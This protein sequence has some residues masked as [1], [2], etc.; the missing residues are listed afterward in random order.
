MLSDHLQSLQGRQVEKGTWFDVVNNLRE[1]SCKS[2]NH[3][4][5]YLNTDINDLALPFNIILLNLIFNPFIYKLWI[6]HKCA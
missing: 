6:Y 1:A 5:S 2:C 3:M 4:L